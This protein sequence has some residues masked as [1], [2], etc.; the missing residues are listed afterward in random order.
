MDDTTKKHILEFLNSVVTDIAPDQA[1]HFLIIFKHD[2][3]KAVKAYRSVERIDKWFLWDGSDIVGLKEFFLNDCPFDRWVKGGKDSRGLPVLFFKKN[4]ITIAAVRSTSM[5]NYSML[6]NLLNSNEGA[7]NRIIHDL[8]KQ[9]EN[10][11]A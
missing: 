6:I 10:K 8:H 3:I 2:L 4:D 9:W 11:N 1:S 7:V 5:K